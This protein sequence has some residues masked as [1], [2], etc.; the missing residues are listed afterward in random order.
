V[1]ACDRKEGL[2]EWWLH[3]YRSVSTADNVRCCSL[4]A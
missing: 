1:T 3:R 2:G 4:V